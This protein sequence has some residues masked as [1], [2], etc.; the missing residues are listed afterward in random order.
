MAT[1][2][3]DINGGKCILRVFR[4]DVDSRE[5]VWHRDKTDRHIKVLQGNGWFFQM[6]DCIPIELKP[7]DELTIP[8]EF[9]HRIFRTGDNDLII[10]ITNK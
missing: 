2:Y 7:M 10:L 3:D 9:Y 6:D 5:L 8:K 1:I 4:A